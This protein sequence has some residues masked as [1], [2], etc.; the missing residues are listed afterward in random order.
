MRSIKILVL[1]G[2]FSLIISGC[3]EEVDTKSVKVS[4]N[5]EAITVTLSSQTPDSLLISLLK[6][7]MR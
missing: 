6:R 5:L 7:V 3:K 1:S 2:L 4:G